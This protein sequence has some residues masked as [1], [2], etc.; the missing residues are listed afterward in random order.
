MHSN[1]MGFL[2][3]ISW[4]IL[5]STRSMI[6]N[7][8]VKNIKDVINQVNKIYLKRGLNTTPIHAAS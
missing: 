5:L 3:A 4:H 8:K 7:W 6:K 2:N 1:D